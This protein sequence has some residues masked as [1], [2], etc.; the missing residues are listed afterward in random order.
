MQ[1]YRMI[2]HKFRELA[3]IDEWEE[4][5]PIKRKD[6]GGVWGKKAISPQFNRNQ[7]MGYFD[8][9]INNDLIS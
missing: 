5:K 6:I 2:Q 4:R 9:V 7:Y 1:R 3:G 8:F